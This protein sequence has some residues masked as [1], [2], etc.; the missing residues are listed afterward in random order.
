MVPFRLNTGVG[1]IRRSTTH[2]SIGHRSVECIVMPCMSDYSWVQESR[3]LRVPENF[4]KI[5]TESS[6]DLWY[7]QTTWE[8][9]ALWVESSATSVSGRGF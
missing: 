4:D 2:L 1:G 9:N 7:L 6:I 8:R 3:R 5:K